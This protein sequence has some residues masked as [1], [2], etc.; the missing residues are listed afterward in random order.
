[1]GMGRILVSKEL[2]LAKDYLTIEN[3]TKKVLEIIQTL[4]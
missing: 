4:R 1:V 3:E 2:M